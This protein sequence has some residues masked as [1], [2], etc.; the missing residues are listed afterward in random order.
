M[1]QWECL[2]LSVGLCKCSSQLPGRVCEFPVPW[3]ISLGITGE[4]QRC[5]VTLAY[6]VGTVSAY[7]QARKCLTFITTGVMQREAEKGGLC[8]FEEDEGRWK[9]SP[10]VHRYNPG[11]HVGEGIFLISLLAPQYI[12]AELWKFTCSVTSLGPGT[13]S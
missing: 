3:G 1:Q 9:D 4:K 11:T 8:T 10:S 13:K 6:S 12:L 5:L 2:S 7:G